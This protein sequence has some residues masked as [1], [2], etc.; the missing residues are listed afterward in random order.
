MSTN[1]PPRPMVR[2][3]GRIQGDGEVVLTSPWPERSAPP[4]S[5]TAELQDV[6]D[7]PRDPD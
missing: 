4:A 3:I 6:E 5:T 1:T 7:D 2:V